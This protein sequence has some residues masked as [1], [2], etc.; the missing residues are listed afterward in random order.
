MHAR[1]GRKSFTAGSAGRSAGHALVRRSPVA[2]KIFMTCGL[3]AVA[4]VVAGFVGVASLSAVYAHGEAIEHDNLRPS[5]Q[6][7][8]LRAKAMQARIAIRDVALSPDKAA[9]LQK[10]TAADAAVTD[11]TAAY[12]PN[13]TDPDAVRKFQ[14]AWDEYR[15][16]RDGEASSCRR[17]GATTSPCS[18]SSRGRRPTRS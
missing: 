4:A 16:V 3:F 12:L 6:L 14:S 10:L 13:A 5:L 1:H 11:A 2:V 7:T 9:A 8:E 18:N 17:P 15:N